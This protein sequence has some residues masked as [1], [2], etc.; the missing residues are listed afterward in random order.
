[1]F[2]EV[3]KLAQDYSYEKCGACIWTQGFVR[4]LQ[5]FHHITCIPQ[6]WLD[7]KTFNAK[8]PADYPIRQYKENQH[9]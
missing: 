3:R 2:K 1:M 8:H 7:P 4:E 9:L 6:K 5:L